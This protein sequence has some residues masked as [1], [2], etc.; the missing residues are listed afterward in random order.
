[1][2]LLELELEERDKVHLSV[3]DWTAV[4][5]HKSRGLSWKLQHFCLLPFIHFA[6]V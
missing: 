4:C 6:S 2:R 3:L 1:M 5:T